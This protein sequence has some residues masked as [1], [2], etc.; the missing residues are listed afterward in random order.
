[1]KRP[2]TAASTPVAR[3]IRD[4]GAES[5]PLRLQPVT[6]EA[7]E[8]TALLNRWAEGRSELGW[9]LMERIYPDL[10]RLAAHHGWSWD[11]TARPS[12]LVQETL[13][14][15]EQQRSSAWT[16]RAHF[17]AVAARLI[18]RVVVDQVK[19]GRRLKRG[20][21]S[22]TQDIE[23]VGEEPWHLDLDVLALHQALKSLART[24]PSAV[25]VVELR[26]FA[27]LSI[28]ETAAVL[29]VGRTTVVRRWRF[30]RAWLRLELQGASVG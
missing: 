24:S 26:Y 25:R 8:T 21:R 9:Q 22:R 6:G 23:E 1:M 17:F 27:G 7:E 13:L 2:S 4:S 12:D 5:G 18:R 14:R 11:L 28:A 30:A 20:G 10:L 3:A 16:D 19:K 29:G 15:L